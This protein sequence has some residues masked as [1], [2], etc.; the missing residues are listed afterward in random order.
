MVGC[1][2]GD[3]S[4]KAGADSDDDTGP[5]VDDDSGDGDD[6]TLEPDDDF[7]DH[8]TGSTTTTTT[9]VPT[10]TST[11]T[12]TIAHTEDCTPSWIT[13]VQLPD[14]TTFPIDPPYQDGDVVRRQYFAATAGHTGVDIAV[15]QNGVAHI[16]TMLGIV[17]EHIAVHPDGQRTQEMIDKDGGREPKIFIDQGGNVH[18]LYQALCLF[19]PFRR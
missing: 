12:T 13:P 17:L 8:E 9:R 1:G 16:V 4:S 14:P 5:G 10:T 19:L 11:T 3:P 2:C 15:D 18:V 6:D 7:P